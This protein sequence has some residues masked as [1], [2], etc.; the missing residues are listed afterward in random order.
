MDFEYN[1]NEFEF[2]LETL[3]FLKNNN[4]SNDD[5]VSE[6]SDVGYS[7]ELTQFILNHKRSLLKSIIKRLKLCLK[8]NQSV[9]EIYQSFEN[10]SHMMPIIRHFFK[11][12]E[13]TTSKSSN[14]K[15]EESEK[16]SEQISEDISEEEENPFD[17]FFESKLQLSENETDTLKASEC[18]NA[19]KD[20]YESN[21]KYDEE[22]PDKKTL[23][24]FL[25]TKLEKKSKSS[26]KY[27][28]MN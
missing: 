16:T 28:I 24:A 10:Y 26:W 18:Y 11:N 8:Y 23:K 7:N 13:S 6:L 5:I 14:L 12:E 22:T 21:E 20:W 1:L 19:F 9:N 3:D 17:A 27:V 25:N 4:A 2:N 15:K